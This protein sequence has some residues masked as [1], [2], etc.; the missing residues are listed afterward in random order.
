MIIQSLISY[1]DRLAEAGDSCVAPE[2]YSWQKIGFAVVLELDGRLHA[3]EDRRQEVAQ[4][5]PKAKPLLKAAPILV[6]GQAKPSQAALASTRIF[7]GTSR[8]TCWAGNL[9]TR[10]QRAQRKRLRRFV[11]D[12]LR[13]S[14]K[15]VRRNILQCADGLRTGSPSN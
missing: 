4:R 14:R 6:P 9:M 2:G 11:R 5:K 12:I 1:Y 8:A 13:Q 15:S 7:C 10:S 3:I